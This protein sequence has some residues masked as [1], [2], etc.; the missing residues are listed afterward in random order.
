MPSLVIFDDN[1]T[2]RKSLKL[3]LSANGYEVKGEY[4][5]SSDVEQI[6]KTL[7]PDLVL[8]DIDMPGGDGIEGVR[9]IKAISPTTAVVMHTVFEDNDKLFQCL[10]HG[11]N[12]YL[13]KKTD[14]DKLVSALQEVFEG[15]ATV[16]P[17]IAKKILGTF[18]QKQTPEHNLSQREMEVLD[19]LVK[20]FS[21]K[22]IASELSLSVETV[23]THLKN[24][25]Y[26]LQVNCAKEAVAVALKRRI[27]Q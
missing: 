22:M 15:G 21:N 1:A 8:M 7:N 20:G 11:A 2:L 24:I 12:G 17:E 18:V 27:V 23:K 13:L 19:L 5:N 14:P 3:L 16:S 26:K 25:Y 9:R 6:I 4:E 10:C